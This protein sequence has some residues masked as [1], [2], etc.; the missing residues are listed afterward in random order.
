VNRADLD[1]FVTH[2]RLSEPSVFVALDLA[3]A[4]PRKEEL[5]HAAV[6]AL[7]VA[8]VLSL[9]A[10]V[11][12]FVAANWQ[13]L[14]VFARFAAL[15]T[16]LI[17]CI[18]AALWRPPPSAIGRL[19]VLGAFVVTGAL[20]AL[21]GQTY[22]TG[23]DIYELFLGWSALAV[24]FVIA[25]RWGVVS[26]AWVLVLNLALTLFCGVNP[27]AG[28][29]WT[30]LGGF[31]LDSGELAV[32]AAAVNLALWI[33]LVTAY[34]SRY[35]AQ[36]RAYAPRWVERFVLAAGVG[37]TT[38]AGGAALL[39]EWSSG[40]YQTD[41]GLLGLAL[42]ALA[43]VGVYAWRRR[44]DVFPLAL[45]TGAVILLGVFA[46]VRIGEFGDSG[47]LFVTAAW[48]V[49]SST[50]AGRFLTHRAR[51]WRREADAP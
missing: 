20:L 35:A 44:S 36:A 28:L 9:A 49:V 4:R 40:R 3:N 14:A 23:A 34:R 43:G 38:W 25:A 41:E 45:V 11:V 16:L 10:G 12:F 7:R 37:F 24:P 31:G 48:L 26:A 47:V 50:L 27:A 29:L 17:T 8:G 32:L 21:F 18:A 33:V 30:M 39:G 42:V 2:H 13:A 6:R 19:S 46:I 5:S 15:Q 51:A 22:Q 1:A